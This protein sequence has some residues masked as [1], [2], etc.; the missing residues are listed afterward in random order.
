MHGWQTLGGTVDYTLRTWL[1]P[2]AAD[3]GALQI[4]SAPGQAVSGQSGTVEASWSG[5]TQARPT[6]GG[7]PLRQVACSA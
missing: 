1:V 7:V 3:T 4:A 6:R 2:L 5:W